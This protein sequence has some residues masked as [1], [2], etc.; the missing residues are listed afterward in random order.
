VEGCVSPRLIDEQVVRAAWT[1]ACAAWKDA[2]SLSFPEELPEEDTSLAFIDLERRQIFF[3]PRFLKKHGVEHALPGLLAH[4]I[5]HHLEYPHTLRLS[6]DLLLAGQSLFTVFPPVFLNLFFDLLINESVGR[7]EELRGQLQALYRAGQGE[8]SSPLFSFYF[9]VYDALWRTPRVLSPHADAE[10]RDKAELFAQTFFSLSS[11]YEQ[12]AYFCAVFAPWIAQPPDDTQARAQHPLLGDLGAPSAEHFP[13]DLTPSP[14]ARRAIERALEE[15]IIPSE[16]PGKQ[17]PTAILKDAL[18]RASQAGIPGVQS[19]EARL[20]LAER[21]YAAHVERTLDALVIPPV[22]G[23][24]DP[25]LPGPLEEADGADASEIDWL[26]S[27]NQRG[28]LAAAAPLR[29]TWDL[30]EEPGEAP[31][32]PRLEIYLDTSGSMPNPAA[33]LNAMTLAAQVLAT[34]AVR[35]GSRVRACV[36]SYVDPLCSEWM[37]S[38]RV[39]RRFL[40]H[41]IGGGTQ[42]PFEV[43]RAWAQRDPGVVRVVISDA[44]FT[45]NLRAADQAAFQATIRRSRHV[46]LLLLGVTEAQVR[47]QWTL[48]VPDK[49]KVVT[50]ESL[51][52]FAPL[53]AQLADSLFPRE[54]R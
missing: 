28:L 35:R 23:V 15:G 50:V 20:V 14:S 36:Y 2:P 45:H 43:A 21:F 34:L 51:D 22:P 31:G 7:D 48:P 46:V 6:A 19:G 1:R 18:S 25:V 3:Q 37:Q 42:F 17:A 54:E 24:R 12:F 44:D 9:A 11:L 39:A 38:E 16:Y 49:L 5:G 27:L 8:V 4:E 10:L 13:A 40:F 32:I 52:D 41:Y 30:D 47:A 29:R 26:G 33:G 53:A